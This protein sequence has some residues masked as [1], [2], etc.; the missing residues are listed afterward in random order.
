VKRGDILLERLR[1]ADYREVAIPEFREW[2]K[3]DTRHE[4]LGEL[5]REEHMPFTVAITR[6]IAW[7]ETEEPH[8][9]EWSRHLPP[10]QQPTMFRTRVII[11][12]PGAAL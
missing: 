2:A 1:L 5:T 4:I 8:S 7:E 12:T 11:S 6:I 3:Q 9:T 10:E